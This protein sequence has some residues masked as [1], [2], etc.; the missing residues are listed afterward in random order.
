MVDYD[1]GFSKVRLEGVL[2]RDRI[3]SHFATSIPGHRE[4]MKLFLLVLPYLLNFMLS[5]K[6]EGNLI[7]LGN[8]YNI[9]L[10]NGTI[11]LHFYW[12]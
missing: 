9:P 3:E 2:G 1:N 6:L 8:N 12:L 4:D 5:Y 7:S 11:L 10:I